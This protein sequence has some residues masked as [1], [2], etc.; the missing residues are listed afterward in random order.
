MSLDS[1]P[2]NEGRV[3]EGERHPVGLGGQ[4]LELRG[5]A[6]PD[7]EELTFR[8]ADGVLLYGRWYRGPDPLAVVVLAHG[9]GASRDDGSI[10]RLAERLARRGFDVLSYDARGHGQSGGLSGCG[11][12]EHLDVAAATATATPRGLPIVHVGVS[13]G[14]IAVVRHLARSGASD[15]DQSWQLGAVLISAPARWR[16]KLTSAGLLLALATRS[17]LGR[18]ASRRW[19]GVRIAKRWHS[20]PDPESMISQVR[21]P[22]YL[23][24]GTRDRLF[25]VNHSERLSRAAGGPSFLDVV[26]DMAHGI[27]EV[28]ATRVAGAVHWVLSHSPE[29]S[30]RS[31][32]IRLPACPTT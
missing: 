24:H 15:S 5:P 21:V 27:S 12:A 28:C 11:S 20:G 4:G 2:V 26:G 6:V 31:G 30:G 7:L 8:T 10:R 14:A 29:A 3:G 16:P 13:M 19:L 32:S 17:A 22:V 1:A 25:G 23:L 18:W 9:F